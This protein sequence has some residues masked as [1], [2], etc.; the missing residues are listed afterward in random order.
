[1]VAAG[2]GWTERRTRLARPVR[3][4]GTNDF[5]LIRLCSA[6]RTPPHDRLGSPTVGSEGSDSGGRSPGAPRNMRRSGCVYRTRRRA[7]QGRSA[8]RSSAAFG[9][10]LFRRGETVT[11]DGTHYASPAA[12]GLSRCAGRRCLIGGPTRNFFRVLR[13]SA[14]R[15]QAGLV[16]AS[17]VRGADP[18]AGR[19]K[20]Q[21]AN[22]VALEQIDAKG[23]CG[24]CSDG[25]SGPAIDGA[26]FNRA[27]PVRS[28]SP[29]DRRAQRRDGL[30]ARPRGD[31]GTC[32]SARPTACSAPG[33]KRSSRQIQIQARNA[34]LPPTSSPPTARPKPPPIIA[35]LR[36]S[37]IPGTTLRG[38][39]HTFRSYQWPPDWSPSTGGFARR[40]G[41][42]AC[43]HMSDTR[44]DQGDKDGRVI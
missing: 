34:G 26:Q 31:P 21:T 44:R 4:C 1:M 23:S 17:R 30:P 43:S 19:S 41:D 15:V 29:T 6:Q 42:L 36:L 39:M 33:P 24:S 8:S 40:P 10:R 2:N 11:V 27:R 12:F 13:A 14:R 7:L 20:H 18:R 16:G 25:R 22:G 28:R 32:S 3:S 9:G 5:R 38:P 37:P 35:A